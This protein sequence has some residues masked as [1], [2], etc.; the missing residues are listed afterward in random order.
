MRIGQKIKELR[1]LKQI[2]QK[3]LAQALNVRQATLSEWESGENEPNPRNR[4]KI[5][6]F[7]NISESELF[8]SAQPTEIR[9]TKIPIV[10]S[11]LADSNIDQL[12]FQ[13]KPSKK[14]YVDLTGAKP[15]RIEGNS[16]APVIFSGQTVFYKEDEVIKEGDLVYFG[17]KNG[18][19]FFKRYYSTTDGTVILHSINIVEHRIREVK[20]KDIEFMYKIVGSW[21]V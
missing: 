16:M 8:G 5:A 12:N 15:I 13:F 20:K 18:T 14:E 11:A 2:Q 3:T 19:K 4:R 17:L 10:S 21:Y 7:F 6:K 1:E 9:T